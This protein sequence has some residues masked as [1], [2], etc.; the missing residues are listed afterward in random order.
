[1][2]EILALVA[3]YDE[4]GANM[5]DERERPRAHHREAN[6]ANAIARKIDRIC[7]AMAGGRVK[8]NPA[9]RLIGAAWLHSQTGGD[10]ALM[11]LPL[12]QLI[13]CSPEQCGCRR[14]LTLIALAY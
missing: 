5:P 14:E 2:R 10:V 12:L 4:Q 6:R 11:I 9:D 8:A 7:R 1:G 3:T 13:G